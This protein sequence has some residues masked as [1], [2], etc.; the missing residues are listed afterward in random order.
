M[1]LAKQVDLILILSQFPYQLL[2]MHDKYG[3]VPFFS[4]IIHVSELILK[5]FK[6]LIIDKIEYS[7][8]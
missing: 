4:H 2:E 3:I 6:R 5:V 7:C 8:S 1:S